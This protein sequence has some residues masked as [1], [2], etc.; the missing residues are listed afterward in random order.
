MK[1][2]LAIVVLGL[3]WSGSANAKDLTGNQLLCDGYTEGTAMA[4]DFRTSTE[5]TFYE[6]KKNFNSR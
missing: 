1:K 3:L 5:G 4:I 2:L 6:I